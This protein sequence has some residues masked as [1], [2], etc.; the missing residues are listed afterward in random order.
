MNEAP[1]LL[2]AS[3]INRRFLSS[4]FRNWAIVWTITAAVVTSVCVV[5]AD[6][7]AA[8]EERAATL[9]A[10]ARP[11]RELQNEHKQMQQSVQQIRERES[12]LVDSDSQ[13][14]LQL[15]G[16]ISRAAG[17]T[18]G[19]VSVASFKLTTI[20]RPL[21]GQETTRMVRGRKVSVP[22]K[23]EQ[24][25]QLTLDGLAVDDLSVAAF[26]TRLR[27]AQVFE[28]VELKSTVSEKVE[29]HDVR[30]YSLTCIY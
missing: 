29:G 13:Q 26:V 8:L 6:R 21:P 9:A 19:K 7:A 12:W 11:V 27:E 2:P 23:M 4:R 1:D 17:G 30:H 28:S 25:M 24:R 10:A 3:V 5:R 22:Q 15:L 18:N 20:E 16:I 14:T